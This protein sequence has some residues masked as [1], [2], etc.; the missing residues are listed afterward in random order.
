ML[1]TSHRLDIEERLSRI[2]SH[3]E[4]LSASVGRGH[5]PADTRAARAV[6]REPDVGR[7]TPRPAPRATPHIEIRLD[8]RSP[9]HER[10]AGVRA[11]LWHL[12]DRSLS[13]LL[14]GRGLAWLGGITTLVGI[15]LFL[16]LAVS[17]GWIGKEARTGLAAAASCALLLGG[18]WLHSRRGR[19]EAAKAMIGAATAAL[20]A[21]LIV[22]SQ[23]YEL[24]PAGL[25]LALA[26]LVGGVATTLAISWAGRAIGAIG[27]V[28]AQL[29]PVLV[30]ASPSAATVAVLALANA[31]AVCVVA[32]ER[33][34]WLVLAS[35]VV[36]APQWATWVLDGQST[37]ATAGAL[38]A[39]AALGMIGAVASQARSGEERLL[40][41]SAAVASLSACLVAAVGRVALDDSSGEAL[42]ELWLGALA[43]A[44]VV[45]GAWRFRRLA[46]AAP[47][48]QLLISIGVVLADVAFALGGSGIALVVGWGATAVGF[49]WLVRRSQPHT[50]DG[51]LLSLGL[52]V[53][54]ALTLLRALIDAPPSGL[55]STDPPLIPLLSVCTLAASCVA[56]GLLIGSGN[57]RLQTAINTVGLASIA[58]LTASALSGPALVCAWCVEAVA[59]MQLWRTSGDAVA[60]FGALGFLGL[61]LLHALVAEAPPVALV[62]GVDDLGAAAVAL[63]A[64]ALGAARAGRT[65]TGD[66]PSRHRLLGSAA[67]TLLYLVSVAIVTVFQPGTE[68]STETVLDLTVRQEGQVLL[69]ALWSVVG[70]GALVMGLRRRNDTVRRLA[71]AWL[72]VAVAK[73]FLYDLSTLTSIF[74]VVSFVVL[75]LLLLAGAYAHQRLR[76]QSPPDL[77]MT[78]EDDS[79][80]QDPAAGGSE[81]PKT[82]RRLPIE[83]MRR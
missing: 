2:E 46:L 39:F 18:A 53:H 35:V 49:A 59:L 5:S 50:R 8:S 24:I 40:R 66:A 10:S 22:A 76:P 58:Y 79:G 80:E 38:A 27:L 45:I 72:M 57:R 65:Q 23:V 14:G 15:V 83:P 51:M 62:T 9:A 7:R 55:G 52:G 25:A 4:E 13:D 32:R 12:P 44:H 67:A 36:C 48:R 1:E 60:R 17:R 29:S 31:C 54:I 64:I 34:S 69:S 20:F 73:V 3:V 74:R 63:G 56:S 43:V 6:R 81:P 11:S 41:A 28:G 21:T 37:L 33:W 75:G 82:P 77:R 26:L 30:G 42:A 47:M 16:G 78:H 61:A 19:T 68:T 70:V 71:L